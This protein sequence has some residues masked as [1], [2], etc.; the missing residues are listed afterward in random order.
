MLKLQIQ[1]YSSKF[2]SVLLDMLG[3]QEIRFSNGGTGLADVKTEAL[4]ELCKYVVWGDS[5]S[6]EWVQCAICLLRDKR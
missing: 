5:V 6:V 1:F 2:N 4:N 3:R